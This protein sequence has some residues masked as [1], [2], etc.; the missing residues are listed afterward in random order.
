MAGKR[1]MSTVETSMDEIR[2]NITLR[3]EFQTNNKYILEKIRTDFLDV[4]GYYLAIGEDELKEY[5]MELHD[6]VV[7]I[8]LQAGYLDD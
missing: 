4:A 3:K 2:I 8:M 1:S 6:Q 5:Y 7:D